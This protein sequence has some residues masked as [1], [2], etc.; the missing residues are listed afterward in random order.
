[1]NLITF[2]RDWSLADETGQ[3]AM[4]SLA[5]GL[6]PGKGI[7][8][9]LAGIRSYHF[10]VRK[11]ARESLGKL[12]AKIIELQMAVQYH[13]DSQTVL[14]SIRESSLFASRLFSE[15]KSDLTVQE[16]KLFTE[17][18]LEA[19]GRGPFYAWRFFQQGGASTQGLKAIALNLS[20][21]ARLALVG[22]YL[23]AGISLKRKYSPFMIALIKSIRQRRSVIRFY[24]HQFNMKRGFD[25]FLNHLDA[26]LR[27]PETLVENELR[28]LNPMAKAESLKAL[29][30][31]VTRIEPGL[32][33]ECITTSGN[34]FV[35][36]AVLD[37]IEASPM[38]MYPELV[39]VLA[40]LLNTYHGDDALAVFKAL[41]MTQSYPLF[42]VVDQVRVVLPGLIPRILEELSSFSRISFFFIQELVLNRS[43]YLDSNTDIY[44]AL[45]HGVAKKRPE[46]VL[47]VLKRH[48]NYS[49]DTVRMAVIS[50]SQTITAFLREEEREIS[51]EAGTMK[52]QLIP[53]A[54]MET[55]KGFFQN[56]LLT[57]V[58]KKLK[59]MKQGS[60][61][62][63]L[64]LSAEII[65]GQDLS[66]GVFA[67]P[68]SFN[69]CVIK[70]SDLSGAS[71]IRTSFVGT[72]FYKTNL[73]RT[74]FDAIR[75]DKAVFIDVT[76]DSA[77]FVECSFQ[78]AS[79]FTSVFDRASMKDAIFSGSVL[80]RISFRETD[81]TGATFACCR[82]SRV[83]FVDALVF[84]TDF[85]GVQ[86]RFS[87]FMPHALSAVEAEFAN[88]NAR[89]FQL[90]SLEFPD[91]VFQLG[92]GPGSVL[93]D[94]DLLILS[95]FI[96]HGQSIFLRRNMF[97][98][99][100]ALDVFKPAQADL[101]EMVPLLIHEN[102]T[103]PGY[104][105]EDTVPYGISGYTP[106]RETAAIAIKCLGV[107][108]IPSRDRVTPY[109]EGL[110][111]MGSI[112]SIAQASDSDI[113]YWVCVRDP[114]PLSDK[115]RRFRDKLDKLEAWALASVGV[116]MH[117]FLVDIDAAKND[118]F[119]GSS[120]ESSGSAQGRILKEEFYRTMIHIAGKIPLWNTLPVCVS[121][122]YYDRIF[123]RIGKNPVT[124]SYLDLGD[125]H[126]I[127]PEEYF[128]A[129]IWQLF[130][131]LKSPFKS[132]MKMALL[133]KFIDESGKKYLLCN[134]FK[135]EWMN[136][137]FQFTLD[138]MDPYYILLR[139][140]VE[141][142]GERG[143]Q[144]AVRL[145]QQCFFLKTQIAQ[146]ADL[147]NTVFGFRQMF[148]SQCMNEWG[149]TRD[150]VF[151][152]GGFRTWSFS[153]ISKLS[154]T[155]E[156]YMIRTY[157]K[158]SQAME[159]GPAM[160]SFISPEDR[161]VLGRKMFVQFSRQP[162]KIG[163]AMLVFRSDSHFQ[164][165]RI[166]YGSRPGQPSFW[167]LFNRG[168]KGVQDQDELIQQA[169]ELEYIGAWLVHN[170]LF[171]G[172]TMIHLVPNP[173]PVTIDDI[174]RLFTALHEF[175]VRDSSEIPF[176]A[177]RQKA[178]ISS[179]FISLNMCVPRKIMKIQSCVLVYENTWGE[180][181]CRSMA[182][183]QGFESMDDLL[184]RIQDEL[185][186]R[187]LPERR[188]F[189]FPKSFRWRVKSRS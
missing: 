120:D 41:V 146:P 87:R 135:D 78:D 15:L 110:F 68:S 117:F 154:A 125:I 174:R 90:E 26:S 126:D 148:I 44:K 184:A 85:S 158:V 165:L 105:P 144:E 72:V 50:L 149:W 140:L 8:P 115:R 2:D 162:G 133:E 14:A 118:Y 103:F 40:P 100:M 178:E 185:G 58:E 25:P 183:D 6:T 61:V 134:R 84:H 167:E 71:F 45:I 3:L 55:K 54:Q 29:A 67:Q 83:S 124:C 102:I 35:V 129:S 36:R 95:E 53:I 16:I 34:M 62:G 114:D 164:A 153:A 30:M 99:L 77:Q 66:S 172:Q 97:S 173:Q 76:A 132:V 12:K 33:M 152:V 60:I 139:S 161:T 150:M 73:S 20:E 57:G 170:R 121:S 64:D 21:D 108:S 48:E 11:T 138:R 113:D 82:V 74:R 119:G 19:G 9:V 65:D 98:L 7:V 180:M 143:N 27:N 106:A 75:F 122:A 169:P 91:T 88:F 94:L 155:L 13:T 69:H 175:F 145:A 51:D 5:S 127:P 186:T 31:M 123:E 79:F 52:D 137:G 159:N 163:K 166:Q 70:D 160:T 43:F 142:Y 182:S 96:Q 141:H 147:E 187:N 32:L 156:K 80:S 39:P 130:K 116:E 47:E 28:V 38:G 37:I 4:V 81:L 10:A 46:R 17:T 63:F 179:L 101:F 18:L 171:S 56:V 92:K 89:T 181:F 128:G 42:R 109:V 176:D 104:I 111:T 151:E 107:P 188:A 23:L 49:N 93:E 112:G 131:W 1:M 177:L 168:G 136:P 24:A 86:A 157:K 59:A 189:Y 22:Q